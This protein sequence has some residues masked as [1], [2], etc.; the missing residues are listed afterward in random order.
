M[1]EAEKVRQYRLQLQQEQ[2]AILEESRRKFQ[3]QF[4]RERYENWC[5]V[6]PV[7]SSHSKRRLKLTG[8]RSSV[9][10]MSGYRCVSDCRSRGQ[11]FDLGPVPY[12]RGD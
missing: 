7:L 1:D 4:E 8:L 5:T 12:F 2:Q 3:E 10:N 11:E 6:K 9:G